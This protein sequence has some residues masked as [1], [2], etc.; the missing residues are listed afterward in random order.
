MD[1]RRGVR[2]STTAAR[3]VLAVALA[4]L[5]MMCAVPRAS[6]HGGELQI[7]VGTDGSGGI[8]A[9]VVWAGD[10]HPVEE[11]VDVTVKA[12]S[13]DGEKVGPIRLQ[14]ASEGVGWYTS[15][16]GVLGEGH[17]TLT[18]RTTEPVTHRTTT[19]IDVVAPPTPEAEESA[20]AD[21]SEDGA[22]AAE[23]PADVD[24]EAAADGAPDQADDVAGSGSAAGVPWGWL[25]AAAVAIAVAAVAVVLRRRSTR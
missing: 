21:A 14:S 18:V 23:G 3:A 7:E 24:A 8:D 6:A 15:E 16:P 10:E 20:A 9:V 12:V 11:T 5:V 2:Q 1:T 19:E 4:L 17:W 13:D 22:Q 25:A